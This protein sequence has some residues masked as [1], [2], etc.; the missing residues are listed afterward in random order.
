MIYFFDDYT[1][2][3]LENF[4]ELLPQ[5]RAEKFEKFRFKR[6]KENCLAAYL[7]LQKVLSEKGIENFEIEQGEN[8]KLFLKDNANLFFNIS[9][10]R[11]GVAVAVDREPIGVDIQDIVPCKEGVMRRV[12]SAEEQ[13][14]VLAASD[15]DR[16]FTRLWTL[17]ESAVKCGGESI[18]DLKKYS[19]ESSEKTFEKYGKVFT[20]F[21]K[22]NLIIS[23]CGSRSFSKIE[24]VKI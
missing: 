17:K 6:D 23:V 21:E 2:L 14:L 24:E 19:F 22:E 12:F 9:H 11:R 13:R 15:R 8:G 5:K 16:A 20:V 4:S 7:V 18:D 3:P 10:C 1:A